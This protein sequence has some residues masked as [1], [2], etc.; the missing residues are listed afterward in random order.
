MSTWF[1]VSPRRLTFISPFFMTLMMPSLL[2]TSDSTRPTRSSITPFSGQRWLRRPVN[3]WPP[4]K[5]VRGTNPVTSHL[6]DF[7][8][9]FLFPAKTGS[10]SQWILQAPS[11]AL[12][13]VSTRSWSMWTDSPNKSSSQPLAPL[14]PPQLMPILSMRPCS[15]TMGSQHQ[16]FRTKTPHLQADSG[17]NS[18]NTW[19]PS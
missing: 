13:M 18:N 17:H 15:D 3:M 16:S 12:L 11:L 4:A 7:S 1:Y 8:N 14:T 10:R 5:A 9:P 2:A 6:L 19:G